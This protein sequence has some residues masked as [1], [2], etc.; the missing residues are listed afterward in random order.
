MYLKDIVG[1]LTDPGREDRVDL[2]EAT[3]S[4]LGVCLWEGG[5]WGSVTA[6][7]VVWCG[8][9]ALGWGDDTS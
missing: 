6:A 3:L 5:R 9:N 8:R 2:E 1:L 7:W 4:E